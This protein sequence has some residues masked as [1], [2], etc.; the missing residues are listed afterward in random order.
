MH[1]Q[2]YPEPQVASLTRLVTYL[3][4]HYHVPDE[5]VVTHRY[6]QQGDHT[7]P[8]NFQWE[9]FIADK[10]FL[11]QKAAGLKVAVL[12]NQA[13]NWETAILPLPE[14]FLEL[15]RPIRLVPQ[16][17][18]APPLAASKLPSPS[19]SVLARP[20]TSA[21]VLSRP[22]SSTLASP[23]TNNPENGD[24]FVKLNS[25]TAPTIAAGQSVVRPKSEILPPPAPAAASPPR[26]IP[27]TLPLRGPI[28]LDPSAVNLLE[29]AVQPA[30]EIKQ[31]DRQGATTKPFNNG[32]PGAPVPTGRQ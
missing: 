24:S 11:Q 2:E 19:T 3:Q 15:H 16:A 17:V 25:A 1:S 10:G 7:D 22:V 29:H 30:A 27:L 6:A 8:V 31:P 26:R 23:P 14:A 13:I 20:V 9:R 21:S 32:L 12:N 18:A 5:N 4:G 28:E